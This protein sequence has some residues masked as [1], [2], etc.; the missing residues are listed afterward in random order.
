MI[1]STRQTPSLF[2]CGTYVNLETEPSAELKGS[3]AARAEHLRGPARW[4]AERRTLKKIRAVPGEIRDIEEVE[5]L[6]EDVHLVSFPESNDL[7][8][9]NVSREN[10]VAKIE[11]RGDG[12][13]WNHLT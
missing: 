2:N 7:P 5:S 3:R 9:S 6:C 12:D 4:L 13:S 8:Q 11:S 10:P 1:L